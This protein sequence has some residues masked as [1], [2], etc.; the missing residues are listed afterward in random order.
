M[1]ILYAEKVFFPHVLEKFKQHWNYHSSSLWSNSAV[2]MCLVGASYVG[3][4]SRNS[5]RFSWKFWERSPH[6]SG[7]R[8]D[9]VVIV[10][11]IQPNKE[12]LSTR[13]D[14]PGVLLQLARIFLPFFHLLTFLSH[15][16]WW[17][18][19]ESYSTGLTFVKVTA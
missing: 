10:K 4:T 13:K 3:F 8:W 7:R 19:A 15:L 17:C 1:L 18:G 2:N 5:T 16:R 14:F 9:T 12:L 6:G 11:Y